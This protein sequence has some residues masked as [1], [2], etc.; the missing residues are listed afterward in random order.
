MI[1]TFY[2]Y[3]KKGPL[4]LGLIFLDSLGPRPSTIGVA[5]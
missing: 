5:Q 3:F 4:S 1:K 2:D